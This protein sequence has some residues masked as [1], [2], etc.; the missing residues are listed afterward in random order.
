M[1]LRIIESSLGSYALSIADQIKK[2]LKDMGYN[3]RRVGVRTKGAGYSD[4]IRITIKDVSIREDDIQKIADR[5]ESV[6]YDE[7]TG[8][9][10]SGGN[11]YITV[12]YDYD[13]VKNAYQPYLEEAREIINADP[14]G[15]S[16][17]LVM[18][19]GGKQLYYYRGHT[20]RDGQCFEADDSY[21]TRVPVRNEYDLAKAMMFFDA[22]N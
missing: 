16:S 7:Y 19:K 6:R 17:V 3:S 9:I 13:A 5:Y 22:Q 18:E 10:L 12:E 11:L 21:G 15:Y 8:E 1:K 20:G 2:E 14:D 4:S